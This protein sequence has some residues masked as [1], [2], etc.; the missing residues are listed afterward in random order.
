MAI[1]SRPAT[2][3]YRDNWP[4]GDKPEKQPEVKINSTTVQ[5]TIGIHRATVETIC[6]YLREW[7]CANTACVI[8]RQ[9]LCGE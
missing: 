9:F 6:S 8:E 3:E 5:A 1:V 2:K 4:F 7:G